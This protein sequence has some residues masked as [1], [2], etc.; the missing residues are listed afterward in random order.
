MKIK[1]DDELLIVYL[2]NQ[3]LKLD[4][5]DN[6]KKDLKTILEDI[7]N[8]Y[9]IT[10]SGIYGIIIYENK[11][12][13]YIL[14]IKQIKEFEYS[15]FIDLRINIKYNQSFYFITDNYNYLDDCNN[16]FYNNN[17]YFVNINSVLNVNSKV[18]LCDILYKD[19][20]SILINCVK[21]K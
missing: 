2:Y 4:E 19:V 18:E 5:L 7:I 14:E 3:D 9:K 16:V 21:I 8:R 10:L 15:E 6:L 13:G 1:F 20:A 12:Y 17:I 11:K